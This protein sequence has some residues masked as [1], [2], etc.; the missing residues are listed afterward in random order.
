ME[1]QRGESRQLP[2]INKYLNYPDSETSPAASHP[3]ID[4]ERFR[5]DG[6]HDNLN[7]GTID[8]IDAPLSIHYNIMPS[9][10][11]ALAPCRRYLNRGGRVPPPCCSGVHE[12]VSDARSAAN[13]QKLCSC[14]TRPLATGLHKVWSLAF[15]PPAADMWGFYCFQVQPFHWLLQVTLSTKFKVLVFAA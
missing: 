5:L 7:G 8:L 14:V 3:N 11:S 15:E 12:L 2:T 10:Y 6:N 4:H 9:A 13:S 1:E